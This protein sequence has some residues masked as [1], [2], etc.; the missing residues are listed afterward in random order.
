MKLMT[1]SMDLYFL[2]IASKRCLS[3]ENFQT[4]SWHFTLISFQIS[5]VGKVFPKTV[6]QEKVDEK[7]DFHCVGLDKDKNVSFPTVEGEWSP[8]G[9]GDE[10]GS[11]S[12][13]REFDDGTEVT[14]STISFLWWLPFVSQGYRALLVAIN[15]D[16]QN[17][18]LRQ[19]FLV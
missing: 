4:L 17:L 5:Q 18:M 8:S 9:P 7:L 2:V 6:V 13:I 1:A 15:I 3:Y 16:F 19:S 14:V 12:P 10:L 11:L